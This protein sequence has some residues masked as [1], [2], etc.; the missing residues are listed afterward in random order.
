MTP[1]KK[2]ITVTPTPEFAVGNVVVLDK[3]LMRCK[4]TMH[5]SNGTIPG[6]VGINWI[7]GEIRE[8]T[9]EQYEQICRDNP[10]VIDRMP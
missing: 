6:G 4:A 5:Y 9:W 1:R 7:P 10:R 3:P 8:L 2:S